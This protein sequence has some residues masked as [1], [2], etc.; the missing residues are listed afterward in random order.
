M[1]WVAGII[2]LLFRAIWRFCRVLWVCRVPAA[3]AV[4]G[5]ALIVFVPQAIDLFAD[6]GLPYWRWALFFFSLFVWAWLVHAMARRALQFDE[7]VPEAHRSGGLS[8]DDRM[9][10]RALFHTP[11]V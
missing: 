7:W 3:S 1:A 11:A 8:D 4:G 9:R 6:T 10:L 2:G 5:G